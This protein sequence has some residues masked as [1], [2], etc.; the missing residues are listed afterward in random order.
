M[1]DKHYRRCTYLCS[2]GF[3]FIFLVAAAGGTIVYTE[4]DLDIG[5]IIAEISYIRQLC[6]RHL[7]TGLAVIVFH[8]QKIKH[9]DYWLLALLLCKYRQ[10]L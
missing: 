7:Q 6:L 8:F 2:L 1:N 9:C 4:V 3:L 5:I 10:T